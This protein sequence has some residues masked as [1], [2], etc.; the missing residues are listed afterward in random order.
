MS[1]EKVTLVICDGLG[2]TPEIAGNA[3]ANAQTPTFDYLLKN[4]PAIRLLAAGSE[5]GLDMG[6]PGNSEVG[7][8]TIGTGQVLPQAFQIINGAIK[9]ESY[10]TN[11]AFL[12]A[13]QEIKNK[14]SKTLHLVGL[15]ASGGVHG[16]ID[17]MIA[18]L[19]LAKER[20]VT[21]V[22]IHAITDGRDTRPKTALDEIKPLVAVLKQFQRGV[23]ASVGGRFYALDRD[24]HW[25]RTD[26]F[27]WAMQ[28]KGRHMALSLEDAIKQGYARGEGDENLQP[29]VITNAEGI[30]AATIQ[31]GDVVILTNYRPDRV[32]QLA[33][34]IISLTKQL[35]IVTMTDY[36]LGRLPAVGNTKTRVFTA[37]KLPKPDGTLAGTLARHGKSQLHVAET[38]KYAHVT[39]FFN[40]HEEKKH[41]R[42]S[43]LLVPSVRVVSFDWVPEMSAPAITAAYLQAKA[44]NGADFTTINYANMDMVAHT[45]NYEAALLAVTA[46]DQQI[47]SLV[48][49]A[50]QKQ[51][52][53]IITSDHGNCEQMINPQTHEIDKEHTTNPVPF[54][55][56]HPKLKQPRTMDKFQL[57]VLSTIGMLADIAPTILDIFQIKKP[58]EMVGG[59]LLEDL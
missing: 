33:T 53:L 7:H 31:D 26:V 32:R 56:V 13:L 44:N 3:F 50:E 52:W 46:I 49:Y 22:A 14:P 54:I 24:T 28:G 21:Q 55:L 4:Y 25:E 18:L 17:H 20:G 30:P 9:S 11:K 8:L 16:H 48:E 42:E 57:A 38:E 29:T 43:W 51:E 35:T 37:Y 5:V 6:E 19:N 59:N 47:R 12:S 41:P 45:G 58:G 27:Y 23:I 40:G 34:R 39:Y 15:V 36:F 10:K 2:L 1:S